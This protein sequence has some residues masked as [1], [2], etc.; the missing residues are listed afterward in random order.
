M[1]DNLTAAT[2]AVEFVGDFTRITP[3]AVKA[4]L[5]RITAGGGI[6]IPITPVTDKSKAPKIKE[7]LRGFIG[8]AIDVPVSATGVRAA[9]RKARADFQREWMSAGASLPLE[10]SFR[11]AP[12]SIEGLRAMVQ[13]GLEA[14]FNVTVNVRQGPG[15]SS[16]GGMIT[17]D[18]MTS[19]QAAMRRIGNDLTRADLQRMITENYP[20]NRD[21]KAQYN[22]LNPNQ[23]RGSGGRFGS[24]IGW[25]EP[26]DYTGAQSSMWGRYGGYGPSR[27][28]G[29]LS[30]GAL[31]NNSPNQRTL[32]F[33]DVARVGG[34]GSLSGMG[35]FDAM[36]RP[37]RLR[38]FDVTGASSNY[39][40][41]QGASMASGLAVPNFDNIAAAFGPSSGPLNI[42][43]TSAM[44]LP[45]WD[46]AVNDMRGTFTGMIDGVKKFSLG[47]GNSFR[48]GI[49]R[50]ESDARRHMFTGMTLERAFTLPALIGGG[51]AIH[52][53]AK[54]QSSFAKTMALTDITP[55][56]MKGRSGLE[57][58]IFGMTKELPQTAQQLADALYFIGSNGFRG[59]EA[60]KVLRAS[61]RGAASG[62]GETKDVASTTTT[63]LA[64]YG[65]NANRAG[66]VVN[67]LTKAVKIGKGEAD[68]YAPALSRVVAIA[69]QVGIPFQQ[70]AANLAVATKIMHS[71]AEAATSLRQVISHIYAPNKQG[72][73]AM[74]E[75]NDAKGNP[76][77]PATMRQ[78]FDTKGFA[79]GLQELMEKSGA[80]KGNLGIIDKIVGNI[81]GLTD[82]LATAGSQTKIYSAAVNEM[83]NGINL[84]DKALKEMSNTF[85]FQWKIFLNSGHSAIQQFTLG[86]LPTLNKA[87]KDMGTSLPAYVKLFTAAWGGL[88]EGIQLSAKAILG[89]L[90]VA[91]P[92]LRLVGIVGSLRASLMLMGVAASANPLLALTAMAATVLILGQN[93][94]YTRNMMQ[95]VTSSFGQA[96]NGFQAMTTVIGALSTALVTLSAVKFGP[97]IAQQIANIGV[98]LKGFGAT[99][100]TVGLQTRALQAAGAAGMAEMGVMGFIKR[101]ATTPIGNAAGIGAAATTATGA[102]VVAAPYTMTGTGMLGAMQGTMLAQGGATATGAASGT[103]GMIA[104]AGAATVSA[105]VALAGFTIAAAA[106]VLV[107]EGLG[108][109]WYNYKAAVDDALNS[110]NNAEV[111]QK[112][113]SKAMQNVEEILPTAH[114]VLQRMGMI[115]KALAEAGDDP[116]KIQRVIGSADKLIRDVK[117]TTTLDKASAAVALNNIEKLRQEALKKLDLQVSIKTDSG[118][119]ENLANDLNSGPLGGLIAFLGKGKNQQGIY[120]PSENSNAPEVAE[121]KPKPKEE[122]ASMRED[123]ASIALGKRVS[124]M[125]SVDLK[126]I[127]I[128]TI[129]QY[130][131]DLNSNSHVRD[132]VGAGRTQ[133]I[134]AR[135][136]TLQDAADDASK[137]KKGGA[138]EESESS[139]NAH[140]EFLQNLQKQL[141][142]WNS[143]VNIIDSVTGKIR[144]YGLHTERAKVQNDL[145]KKSMEG[146]SQEAVKNAL[147]LAGVLDKMNA[148]SALQKQERE[149]KGEL[150]QALMR[151]G[152]KPSLISDNGVGDS[153]YRSEMK[154]QTK[155][156][157]RLQREGARLGDERVRY[158]QDQINKANDDKDSTGVDSDGGTDSASTKGKPKNW[159][160]GGAPAVHV[161][162]HGNHPAMPS[163]SLAPA[164]PR[165]FGEGKSRIGAIG[166]VNPQFD[167]AAESGEPYTDLPGWF[168]KP[169]KQHAQTFAFMIKVQNKEY[170]EKLYKQYGT[171]LEG[172]AKVAKIV[173]DD[174]KDAIKTDQI[175]SERGGDIDTNKVIQDMRHEGNLVGEENN[176]LAHMREGFKQGAENGAGV[177]F[178]DQ[179]RRLSEGA[180]LWKLKEA[181]ATDELAKAEYRKSKAL[182]AGLPFLQAQTFSTREYTMAMELQAMREEEWHKTSAMRR[183]NPEEANKQF[184]R[185]VQELTGSAYA[186]SIRQFDVSETTLSQDMKDK[187]ANLKYRQSLITGGTPIEQVGPLSDIEAASVI[188]ERELSAQA[189]AKLEALKNALPAENRFN[190]Q[191]AIKFAKEAFDQEAKEALA[192]FRQGLTNNTMTGIGVAQNEGDASF[193]KEES[194]RFDAI[195]KQRELLGKYANPH[196]SGLDIENQMVSFEAE[197]RSK[198]LNDTGLAAS[199]K[200]KRNTLTGDASLKALTDYGK[201][202]FDVQQRLKAL[203][204]ESGSTARWLDIYN[205]KVIKGLDANQKFSL[206]LGETNLNLESQ[207]T[208]MAAAGSMTRTRSESER[209]GIQARLNYNAQVAAGHPDLA[210]QQFAGV[211]GIIGQQKKIESDVFGFGEQKQVLESLMSAQNQYNLEAGIGAGVSKQ[212]REELQ[213]Q[214]RL[215]QLLNKAMMVGANITEKDLALWKE[216][217]KKVA[218]FAKAAEWKAQMQQF[219]EGIRSAIVNGITTSEGGVKGKLKRIF[220]DITKMFADIGA[221]Y[222]GTAI[223]KR[224]FGKND[225]L[226]QQ[227]FPGKRPKID[228][229]DIK[230]ITDKVFKTPDIPRTSTSDDI[231]N[232]SVAWSGRV[233]AIAGILDK[234]AAGTDAVTIDGDGVI[235]ITT[236]GA[237]N[238]NGATGGG[239][240]NPT[241]GLS[242]DQMLGDVAQLI[243]GRHSRR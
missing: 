151:A 150:Q 61:A 172:R 174:L 74:A 117:I 229:T 50:V 91:G 227:K 27:P 169:N 92:L 214:F 175:L 223:T 41:W 127:G 2:M 185:R 13:A 162:I 146:V 231:S 221:N 131:N 170:L 120:Y 76:Y 34:Q 102:A 31:G 59:A 241:G 216:L 10:V 140:R 192:K 240:A 158:Y 55:G 42:P 236:S 187:A 19:Q 232:H 87:M 118:W 166:A 72:I 110:E 30:Y 83:Y 156:G 144:E 20:G 100:A 108:V 238:V 95:G 183:E 51:L 5:N 193:I 153:V 243:L 7:E 53:T 109:A 78:M 165:W 98:L 66:E 111:S 119:M 89:F 130:V 24:P 68:Q 200:A 181:H 148:I 101:I 168:P 210:A 6:A 16:P 1:A 186:Q 196:D 3:E 32:P 73:D 103:S 58:Q 38:P 190:D 237:V 132:I 201:E 84:T 85:D 45:R 202:T 40:R 126:K 88:P 219:E 225:V 35:E 70:V 12:G 105:G 90:V 215:Q 182:A 25:A 75:I 198:H 104:G 64:A 63:V 36:S 199:S 173:A 134:L 37:A 197:Y 179:M 136:K 21:I 116:V 239:K 48:D 94:D 46:N 188:K 138:P 235:T 217:D 49:A 80:N 164:N 86:V 160:K 178:G 208:K 54:L 107:L 220:G 39:G 161:H 93:F 194:Y 113:I 149:N 122:F 96:T 180:T 191:D 81:R 65:L 141:S 133:Q 15:S 28:I 218:D 125:Q 82:I 203:G 155:E 77:T 177:S 139:K 8:G 143:Y 69:S 154:A 142:A 167:T 56:E 43:K 62:L 124:A 157:M 112:N 97:V 14:P 9:A 123:A 224:I 205:D 242:K 230:D 234:G 207:R 60:M 163:V 145:L 26:I 212:K 189:N 137:L 228:V 23:P 121:A 115:N 99:I 176:P 184:N 206:A 226:E 57:S 67:V 18:V 128:K 33:Y 52:D 17:P 44:L 79:G 213:A 211:S 4:E 171:T 135:Q 29:T 22:P 209:M 71:P 222:L 11:P 147:A 204:D 233:G 47:F 129:D 114:P 159:G 195:G 152:L 106:A